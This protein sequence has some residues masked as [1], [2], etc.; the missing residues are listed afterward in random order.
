MLQ[1]VLPPSVAIRPWQ[2]WSVAALYWGSFALVGYAQSTAYW[3]LA[4]SPW[5]TRT[6]SLELLLRGLLW[7]ASTPLILYLAHRAP[8][9]SFRH[10]GRHLA[11][12]VAAQF[13]LNL[14][15]TCGCY[16]L[17]YWLAG[18]VPGRTWGPAGVWASMLLRLSISLTMYLLLVVAYGVV[19]YALR[20]QVLQHQNVRYEL[21][22]AQ[23]KSQL[24]E[25]QLQTLKMQLNPHFLFNAHH[26]IIGLILEQ[27]PARAIAVVTS[28][29]ELL[30]AVLAGGD[31]QLIPLREE[32]RLVQQYLHIQ[33]IRFQDRLHITYELGA[34]TSECLFPSF[35]LQPLVENAIVHSVEQSTNEAYLCLRAHREGQH[36]LV[37]VCDNGSAP[38]RPA[39]SS[40]RSHTG[41][42]LG[43]ASA[44]LE[45]LYQGRAHLEFVQPTTGGA[46]VRV[47]VP[48]TGPATVPT[49][50]AS[51]TLAAV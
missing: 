2:F 25:A 1:A 29:S 7:W 41:I 47:R 40:P 51:A 46:V 44:R 19:S 49:L 5:F 28:L 42:G 48:L 31:A 12:H 4:G 6:E 23:L 50:P 22:T 16:L 24:A 10:L 30:R 26:T 33:Q 20:N 45:K 15:I 38:S 34:D 18:L 35:L 17:L 11:L 8:L 21:L 9:T 37:E 14:L 36:L 27:E 43:N 13:S 39:K 32:W 3:S